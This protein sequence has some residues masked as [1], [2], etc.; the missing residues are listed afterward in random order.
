MTFIK[1]GYTY[2]A[3][4]YLIN[5]TGE[6]LTGISANDATYIQ[7]AVNDGESIRFDAESQKTGYHGLVK[8]DVTIPAHAV[9]MLEL[10]EE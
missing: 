5:N 9:V 3:T 6:A 8:R 1:A 4:I 10:I 2:T 7:K